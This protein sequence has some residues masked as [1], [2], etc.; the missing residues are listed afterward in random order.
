MC[1]LLGEVVRHHLPF[2]LGEFKLKQNLEALRAKVVEA[3]NHAVS[4]AADYDALLAEI[5]SKA[6]GV[7]ALD[8]KVETLRKVEAGLQKA[9]EDLAASQ[10]KKASVEKA[11]S[12]MKK[13]FE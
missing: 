4:I 10:Q 2:F 9:N 5:D 1:W 11:I 8:T 6:A 7:D 13:K 3:Q 12:D